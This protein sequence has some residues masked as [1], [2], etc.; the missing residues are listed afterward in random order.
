VTRQF[1]HHGT[2]LVVTVEPDETGGFY[3]TVPALP[4]AGS[5]G[6]SISDALANLEDAIMAVL[7]VLKEDDP[8][9]YDEIMGSADW[10]PAA[11]PETASSTK[12]DAIWVVGE[13]RPAAT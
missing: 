3:A 5:Q 9:R 7:E 11:Q 8:S 13:R 1:L 6:E 10:V 2:G 4:G 12:P